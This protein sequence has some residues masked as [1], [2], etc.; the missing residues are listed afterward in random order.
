MDK[1]KISR[2]GGKHVQWAGRTAN[3]RSASERT[4]TPAYRQFAH[5]QPLVMLK[6]LII[7]NWIHLLSRQTH[8]LVAAE[9]KQPRPGASLLPTWCV[10]GRST[11]GWWTTHSHRPPPH[12]TQDVNS[13]YCAPHRPH[14]MKKKPSQIKVMKWLCHFQL[15]VLRM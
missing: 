4:W 9:W 11:P 8:S 13:S 12:P 10:S 14:H 3:L 1:V 5:L 7:W 15:H 2:R 6:R